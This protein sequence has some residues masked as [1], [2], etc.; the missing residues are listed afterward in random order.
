MRRRKDVGWT[1]R[2]IAVEL[3]ARRLTGTRGGRWQSMTVLRL[4]QRLDLR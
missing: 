4:L 3:N 1:T 2:Q